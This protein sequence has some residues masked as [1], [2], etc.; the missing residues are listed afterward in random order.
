MLYYRVNDN[1]D[2]LPYRVYDG[3][4]KKWVSKGF[5]VINEL[6]TEK[7]FMRMNINDLAFDLIELKKNQVRKYGDGTRYQKGVW[8]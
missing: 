8:C 1:G 7:E 2:M 4:K 6:Y 3:R 5:L